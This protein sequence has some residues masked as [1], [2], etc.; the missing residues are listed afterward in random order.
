MGKIINIH[1]GKEVEQE[2]RMPDMNCCICKSDFNLEEEGGT[3]GYFGMCLV[4]FCPFCLSSML[5][6]AKQML[7]IQ[8]EP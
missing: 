2:P 4:H 3:A 6:M 5:D 1:T 8:E 7:N